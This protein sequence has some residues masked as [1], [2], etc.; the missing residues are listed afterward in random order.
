MN[1][2]IRERDMTMY[3]HVFTAKQHENI[4][5]HGV[6]PLVHDKNHITLL[7]YLLRDHQLVNTD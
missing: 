7:F 6:L 4:R 2:F 1:Y 3:Y 5:N